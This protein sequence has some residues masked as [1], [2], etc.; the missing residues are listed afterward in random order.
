MTGT[1]NSGNYNIKVII[2]FYIFFACKINSTASNKVH[3]RENMLFYA[4][5]VN[6]NT[7]PSGYQSVRP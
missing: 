3:L 5:S 4:I 7:D 6:N 2:Y 1:S